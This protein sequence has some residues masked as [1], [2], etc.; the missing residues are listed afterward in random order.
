MRIRNTG[1]GEDNIAQNQF[2]AYLITAVRRKKSTYLQAQAK[3][4]QHE[5]ATDFTEDCLG[6]SEK[7]EL[8]ESRVH[9]SLLL[10]NTALERALERMEARERLILFARV[11]DEQDF[12]SLA[13]ELG[14]TYKGV[15]SAYY[16]LIRKIK[17]GLGGDEP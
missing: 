9:G 14:L 15:T 6:D 8:M 1:T 4:E 3:L 7:S 12:E 10:E 17:K 11:L 2:T 16:R 13:A 5:I